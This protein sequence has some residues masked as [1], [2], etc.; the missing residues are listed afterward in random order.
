MTQQ[1]R[2]ARVPISGQAILSNDQGICITATT[3]DISQ[4]GIGINKPTDSLAETEYQIRIS[5]DTG[6]QIHLR[7][8]LIHSSIHTTGFK[9]S[10]I[11]KK[12]LQIITDL[13]AEYQST[14][15]FI[16]QIDEH[17]LLKQKYIDEDGNEVSVTFDIK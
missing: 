5:T 13:V 14:E 11:N 15:A 9:T 1:R 10:D 6:R 3:K 8:T 12:N 7:A 17:D 2:Q 16:K 4:D